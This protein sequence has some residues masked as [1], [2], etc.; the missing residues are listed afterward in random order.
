MR[1]DPAAGELFHHF[2]AMELVNGDS[3]GAV[4]RFFRDLLLWA[5]KKPHVTCS[6][7]RVIARLQTSD[8]AAYLWLVNSQR[9]SITT[10]VTVSDNWGPYRK[11]DSLRGEDVDFQSGRHVSAVVPARDVTVVRL[12]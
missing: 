7:N 2:G 8:S 6:D 9:H 1:I 5:G 4:N 11:C 12:T 10:E 3:E